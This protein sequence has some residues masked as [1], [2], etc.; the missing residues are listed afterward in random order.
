LALQTD[1]AQASPWRS[2]NASIRA[3]NIT[4]AK[5]ATIAQRRT[6]IARGAMTRGSKISANLTWELG[7]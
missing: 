4:R 3:T 7:S 1:M 2:A 6:G 5:P